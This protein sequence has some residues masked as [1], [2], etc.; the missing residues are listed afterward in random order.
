MRGFVRYGTPGLLLL[1]ARATGSVDE[2]PPA[3]PPTSVFR[4][5][6]AQCRRIGKIPSILYAVS[7]PDLAG[8]ENH[9]EFLVAGK[10]WTLAKK[11]IESIDFQFAKAF[12]GEKLNFQ[13]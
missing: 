10:K 11:G 8:A 5:F 1:R 13:L 6:T 3:E 12:C 7:S 2:T 4:D 9:C